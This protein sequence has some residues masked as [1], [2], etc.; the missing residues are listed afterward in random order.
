MQSEASLQLTDTDSEQIEGFDR[1]LQE[2]CDF[3]DASSDNSFLQG[4][5]DSTKKKIKAKNKV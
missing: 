4:G 2:L 5:F 3:S 1:I